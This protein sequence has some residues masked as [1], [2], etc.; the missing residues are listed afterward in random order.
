VQDLHDRGE[1][2][3]RDEHGVHRRLGVVVPVILRRGSSVANK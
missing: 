3:V 1:G 2:P